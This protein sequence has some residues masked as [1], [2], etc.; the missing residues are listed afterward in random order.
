M[1]KGKEKGGRGSRR[2]EEGEDGHNSPLFS[3]SNNRKKL[4]VSILGEGKGG[5]GKGLVLG[6]GRKTAK[7]GL[8]GGGRK[9]GRS[10]EGEQRGGRE[11]ED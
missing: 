11:G 4:W 3:Y 2:R 1:E 6:K 5:E 8:R 7:E 9:A 10:R